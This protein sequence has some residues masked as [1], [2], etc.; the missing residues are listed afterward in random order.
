MVFE[1]ISLEE[2]EA[3]KPTKQE[4]FLK[5]KNSLDDHE[6]RI[7]VTEGS[8]NAFL[9]MDFGLNGPY[10]ILGTLDN[11]AGIYRVTFNLTITSIRLI[12]HIAGS[13][14]SSETNIL[15]KRGVGA[16]TTVLDTRP[17]LAF[18][19]GNFAISTNAV[20]NSVNKFLQA[21]DLVKADL[22]GSQGGEPRGLV[23]IVEFEKT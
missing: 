6:D 4:L 23:T 11:Y 15:F 21:G 7:V 10:Q 14:G 8:L 2:I 9:P 19:T 16:F 5:S 22:T 3:G 1:E 12:T 20:L 17:S 13:S 18:G